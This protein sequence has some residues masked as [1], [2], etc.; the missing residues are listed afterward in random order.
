MAA[1]LVSGEINAEVIGGC[2]ALDRLVRLE[3]R[4]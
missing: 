2:N 4:T 3:C 1:V